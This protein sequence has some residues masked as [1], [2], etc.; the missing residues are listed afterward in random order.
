MPHLCDARD[1]NQ[2]IVHTS[3]APYQLNYNTFKGNLRIIA[4]GES[5]EE[6]LLVNTGEFILPASQFKTIKNI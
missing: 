2:D 6:K 4:Q 5:N 1:W 3:K